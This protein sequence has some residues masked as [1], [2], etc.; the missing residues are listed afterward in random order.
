MMVCFLSELVAACSLGSARARDSLLCLATL[1][2]LAS[3]SRIYV[4]FLNSL[5]FLT[6]VA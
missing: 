3:L 4:I 1:G 5:T 2:V 6:S